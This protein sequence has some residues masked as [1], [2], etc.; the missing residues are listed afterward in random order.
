MHR[1]GLKTE[2]VLHIR[3]PYFLLHAATKPETTPQL[4]MLNQ[5][6]LEIIT[7]CPYVSFRESTPIGQW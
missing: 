2:K 4:L 1:I 6:L 7:Q 5:A 3:K